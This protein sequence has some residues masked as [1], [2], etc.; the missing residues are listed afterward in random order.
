MNDIDFDWIFY[1]NYYPDLKMNGINTERK[2]VDHYQSHGRTEAR[3]THPTDY[4]QMYHLNDTFGPLSFFSVNDTI[5]N[6]LK[7]LIQMNQLYYCLEIGCGIGGFANSLAQCLPQGKYVGIDLD[8]LCV[9][10]CQTHIKAHNIQFNHF[11]LNHIDY[12]D[13]SFDIIYLPLELVR[14]NQEQINNLLLEVKRVLKLNGWCLIT[15]FFWNPF[16]ELNLKK[17]KNNIK[18]IIIKEKQISLINSLNERI[19]VYNEVQMLDWC[20]NANLKL[21]TIIYGN[22][23]GF[24][25]E[26]NYKDCVILHKINN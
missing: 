4:R 2:A 10:W 20:I 26:K 12:P 11:K 1:V 21:K 14:C 5:L 15:Y 9:T 19:E 7:S 8:P 13:Q 3:I 25:Q 16:F 22:W 6:Y 24:S 17:R 23:S 18:K